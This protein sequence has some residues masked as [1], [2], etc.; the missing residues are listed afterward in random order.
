[1]SGGYTEYRWGCLGLSKGLWLRG[2]E[3]Y[4]GS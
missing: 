4:K 3:F 2:G 1:M